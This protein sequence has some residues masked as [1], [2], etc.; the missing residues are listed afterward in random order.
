MPKMPVRIRT[1]GVAIELNG[2]IRLSAGEDR[3]DDPARLKTRSDR[4]GYSL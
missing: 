3:V 4:C 1:Q 2:G